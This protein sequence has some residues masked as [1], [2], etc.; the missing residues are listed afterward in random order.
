MKVLD[1]IA[2][3]VVRLDG[4]ARYVSMN[5][6]AEES[7]RRLGHDPVSMIGRS[8]WELFPDVK[9]TIV[10]NEL[11]RALEDDAP[12][13]YEFFFPADRHWYETDGFP[14]SPGVL[15]IFRD[16]TARKTETGSG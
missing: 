16:I 4:Q 11:R 12:I 14:A 15:L 6:A 7:F 10:E 13:H 3:P 5:R 9:G 1:D 8:V 2:D